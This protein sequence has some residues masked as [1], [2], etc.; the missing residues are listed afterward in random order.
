MNK[1]TLF[2]AFFMTIN[3]FSTEFTFSED[4]IWEE[5]PFAVEGSTVVS[6]LINMS[7]DSLYIDSIGL[8]IDTVKFPKYEIVWCAESKEFFEGYTFGNLLGSPFPPINKYNDAWFKLMC[9]GGKDSLKLYEFWLDKVLHGNLNTRDSIVPIT[10]DIVFFSQG[11]SDT[12]T[13]NGLYNYDLTTNIMKQNNKFKIANELKKQQTF[14][15]NCLGKKM[16]FNM[17]KSDIRIAKGVFLRPGKKHI[18]IIKQNFS[19]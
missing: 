3:A 4:T 7:D 5:I 14:L 17:I 13:L 12:L 1:K 6:Y 11:Y 8:I 16:H 10:V 2:I 19:H 18:K 9:S 15:Y